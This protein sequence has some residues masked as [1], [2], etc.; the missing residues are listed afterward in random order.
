MPKLTIQMNRPDPF[1]PNDGC[2]NGQVYVHPD[3]LID[4]V[5]NFWN[6]KPIT[7]AKAYTASW[8]KNSI[9]PIANRASY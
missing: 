4:K 1:D 6:R 2:G 5:Y 8:G 3:G 7:V 9:P